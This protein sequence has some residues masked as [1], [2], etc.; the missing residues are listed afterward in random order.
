MPVDPPLNG[1]THGT[2]DRPFDV[3]GVAAAR[4]FARF[5]LLPFVVSSTLPACFPP[6]ASGL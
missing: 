2:L 4:R 3:G 5:P 6:L 1:I